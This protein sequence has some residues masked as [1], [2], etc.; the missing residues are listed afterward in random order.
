LEK[1]ER[2]ARIAVFV[3]GS[4]LFY[5][6]KDALNTFIDL[7]KL[8]DFIRTFGDIAD[9]YYYTGHDSQNE[10]NKQQGF[11]DK[12]PH[13]G[14]SVVTKPLKTFHDL[15]GKTSKQKANL[16]VEIVLDMFNTVENYDIAFLISGDG[17]FV[18]PIEL[19]RAKGKRFK[20]LATDGHIA[21]DLLKLAGMHYIDFRD[22]LDQL[23]KD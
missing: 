8:L 20:I 2:K 7:G 10:E 9:A 1:T 3:D 6:Q 18:R 14:F 4:N 19:L 21:Q 23:K 11:I 17:D 16:D 15:F 13:L 22:I 5:M 12:L